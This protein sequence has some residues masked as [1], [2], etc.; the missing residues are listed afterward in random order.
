MALK[1]LVKIGTE[2]V[3]QEHDD[4][5]APCP[6]FGGPWGDSTQFVWRDAP[7][8]RLLEV[9]K[10]AKTQEI[11]NSFETSLFK[12]FT[13]TNGIK[14]D[15]NLQS[16]QTLNAGYDLS[17]KLSNTTMDIRDFSN[18]THTT[19]ALVDVDTM[20]QELGTNWQTQWANKNTKID[21]IAAKVKVSTVESI[22]W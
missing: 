12:G 5:N 10:D 17:V 2:E 11:R 19:V 7:S 9:A 16:I 22:T 18:V 3:A 15:A 14:M 6:E 13:C 20:I 21:L 8:A 1:Q 4:A